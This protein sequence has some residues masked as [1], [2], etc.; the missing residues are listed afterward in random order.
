VQIAFIDY[1]QRLETERTFDNL[2]DRL[3]Y[4]SKRLV[5]IAKELNIPV[6]VGAQVPAKVKDRKDHRNYYDTDIADCTKIAQDADLIMFVHREH[7]FDTMV[8][9]TTGEFIVEKLRMAGKL[10]IASAYFNPV[11]S[12]FT[13]G[14]RCD[15]HGPMV[16][17]DVPF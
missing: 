2:Y 7:R 13:N 17:N 5:D 4:V 11:T 10:G 8:P 15:E 16:N 3:V 1:Y 14:Q 6:I 12:Q 9:E